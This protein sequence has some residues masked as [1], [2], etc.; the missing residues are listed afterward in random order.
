[1]PSLRIV[2]AADKGGVQKTATA[3]L[4]IGLLEAQNRQP[5]IVE[6]ERP[7]ERKLTAV[8][9]R[10]GR[11]PDLYV[12]V[13]SET[14]LSE[15]PRLQAKTFAPVL[16]MLSGESDAV[17]DLA[18]GA[19]RGLLEAAGQAEHGELTDG[20]EG[21]VVLAVARAEDLQSL[22]SAEAAAILARKIYPCA[23]V[24]GVITS[25]IGNNAKR[26]SEDLSR[27]T[28]AVVLIA[29]ESSPLTGELYGQR[30]LPFAMIAGL[31]LD[32]ITGLV[33]D[34]TREEAAIWRGRFR[35]WYGETMQNLTEAL[36]VTTEP[37]A[38]EAPQVIP[39]RPTR[40]AGA[41]T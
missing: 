17:V 1:M 8:L 2:V 29:T 32:A 39:S 6:V 25:V 41:R 37:A 30:H 38:D 13:P 35:R 19:T 23:R 34:M 40:V 26:V 33:S 21:I 7:H 12:K 4:V 20:G 36:G 18:A 14:E 28:D 11:M 10:Q 24:I 16:S 27:S 15:D 9:E 3:V 5:K 22:A 31:S